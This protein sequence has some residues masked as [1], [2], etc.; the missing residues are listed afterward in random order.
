MLRAQRTRQA[1]GMVCWVDLSHTVRQVTCCR[2]PAR[3]M[4]GG[5]LHTTSSKVGKGI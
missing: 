4:S 2:D 1:Y 3:G 5:C